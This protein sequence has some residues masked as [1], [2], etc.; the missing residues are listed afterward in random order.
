MDGLQVVNA[1]ALKIA[2][3]RRHRGVAEDLRQVEQIPAR[4]EIRHGECVAQGMRRATHVCD[5][6]PC[7]ECFE[8]ALKVPNRQPRAETRGED[9]AFRMS[10]RPSK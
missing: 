10:L 4:P 3:R 6:E 8:V 9:K 2:L 7:A 5:G 1:E